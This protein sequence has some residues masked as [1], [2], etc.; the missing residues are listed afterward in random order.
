[1][2]QTQFRVVMFSSRSSTAVLEILREWG[3]EVQ[4]TLPILL[5]LEQW[6]EPSRQQRVCSILCE[7]NTNSNPRTKYSCCYCVAGVNFT[8]WACLCF[9]VLWCHYIPGDTC[10]GNLLKGF[11]FVPWL[12]VY[13]YF[14]SEQ[15]IFY[16]I[17][18]Y[19]LQ[20]C[21]SDLNQEQV[22]RFFLKVLPEMWVTSKLQLNYEF[23]CSLRDC[24]TFC[25]LWH[26]S[27]SQINLL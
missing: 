13:M 24:L 25:K 19:S 4:K 9:C 11:F 15:T 2:C 8:L 14:Y 22:W 3:K 17:A 5:C 1:M 23:S 6:A 12:S 27:N 26:G 20:A 16:V 21:S 18:K 7:S 10:S